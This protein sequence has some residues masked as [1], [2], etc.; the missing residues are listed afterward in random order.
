MTTKNETFNGQREFPIT[1]RYFELLA[2]VNPVDVLILDQAGTVLA[3]DRAVEAGYW[4]ERQENRGLQPFARIIITTGGAEAVKFLTSDGTSGNRKA[5]DVIDRAARLLGIVYGSL[6]QLAQVLVNAVNYLRVQVQGHGDA[7]TD[8]GAAFVWYGSQAAVAA[9]YSHCQLM[10]AAGSGKKVYVDRVEVAF[11][12]GAVS[13]VSAALYN[14]AMTTAGAAGINR[15]SGGAAASALFRSQANGT[16]L[17][18]LIGTRQVLAG[19][20]ATFTFEPPIRLDA[21]KGLSVN[22]GTLNKLVYAAFHGREY[23]A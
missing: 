23:V 10:N 1:A 19:E 8:A 17:G 2:T 9:E 16:V 22:G 18:T 11:D 4:H 7:E 15:L 21:G 3:D 13:L 20:H 12:A 5:A 6:G 14:T